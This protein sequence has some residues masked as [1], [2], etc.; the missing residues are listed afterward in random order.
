MAKFILYA[1]P[2]GPLANQIDAYFER[3]Q[4]R[5]G[6]NAAH[7]YMPHCTLTGFF[8]DETGAAQ[9]Y[10]ESI[11]K[12]L[13]DFRM[14]T[15]QLPIKIQQLSFQENWH[16]LVLKAETLK[17]W[18]EQ[19]AAIAH[20]PTRATPL[21]LKDWLHLSLAYDFSPQHATELE[22]IAKALIDLTAAVQWEL[23]F[24]QRAE[25]NRWK[26]HGRWAL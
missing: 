5:C 10:V 15:P 1:C 3:S 11:T 17:T 18:V 12:S 16:G 2:V 20:S 19:F 22:E 9:K 21:R 24:Y 25:G 26:V 14:H 4:Q 23:R 13:A 7:A 8:E 6:P